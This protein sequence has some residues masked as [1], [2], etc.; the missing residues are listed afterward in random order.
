MKIVYS[1]R[2]SGRSAQAEVQK[3][4][5][6]ALMG[7]A[8]GDEFDGSV[9]GLEGFRLKITGL[10]DN[11]GTPSRKAVAGSRKKYVL[12]NASHQRKGMRTRVLVRGNTVSAD[13]VQVNAAIESY[14]SKSLDEIFPKKEKQAEEKKE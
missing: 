1:D 3:D 8:I 13:T 5:E 7:K 4:S 14:G 6:A 11:C 10:S 12:M 9:A 2:K